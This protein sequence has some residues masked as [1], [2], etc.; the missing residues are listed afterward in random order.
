MTS[1]RHVTSANS[2]R[3]ANAAE[4]SKRSAWLST[5]LAKAS[6]KSSVDK[7]SPSPPSKTVNI[8]R[9]PATARRKSYSQQH[10]NSEPNSF[11]VPPRPALRPPRLRVRSSTV[12][13]DHIRSDES[14]D[15]TEDD[16]EKNKCSEQTNEKDPIIKDRTFE[17]SETHL[18]LTVNLQQ[19]VEN[20]RVRV[21]SG[22]DKLIIVYKHSDEECHLNIRLP[23]SVNP[24][25]V[26][27]VASAEKI[28][29]EAPLRN[30]IQ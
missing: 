4:A 18:K 20:V 21:L 12:C 5:L 8:Y 28:V 7:S 2:G 19:S 27:A 1:D 24:F 3:M 29:V 6:L 9:Q 15:S 26:R 13:T 22:G 17:I 14:D 10:S 16:R 23:L 11:D 25:A 30:K